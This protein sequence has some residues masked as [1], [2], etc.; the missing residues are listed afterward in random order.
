MNLML[1]FPVPFE[2]A[3]RYMVGIGRSTDLEIGADGVESN[4]RHPEYKT[5]ALP[6]ELRQHL[7]DPIGIE[8]TTFRLQGGCSPI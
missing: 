5:G 2:G 4:S 8:P 6:T 3:G 7:V 1:T